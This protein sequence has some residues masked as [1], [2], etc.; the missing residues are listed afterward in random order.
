MA[1]DIATS[2]RF[3]TIGQPIHENEST[4]LLCSRMFTA[5]VCSGVGVDAP[6]YAIQIL[7]SRR[8][9]RPSVLCLVDVVFIGAMLLM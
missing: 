3:T 9:K 1:L 4:S 2:R 6:L 5:G 7:V 8:Y